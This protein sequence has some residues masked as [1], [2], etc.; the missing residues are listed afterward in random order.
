MQDGHRWSRCLRDNQECHCPYTALLAANKALCGYEG[1]S[2]ID[3]PPGL[4][5]I[6][7][8]GGFARV[9]ELF[10]WNDEMGRIWTDIEILFETALEN[11]EK[12]NLED[13]NDGA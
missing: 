7:R 5:S 6:L 13:D 12:F 10:A 11:I 3:P 2:S 8:A 1:A 9:S 4:Q